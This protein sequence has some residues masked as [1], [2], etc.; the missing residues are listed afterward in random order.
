MREK[1][2]RGGKPKSKMNEERKKA[3]EKGGGTPHGGAWTYLKLVAF[4]T[5]QH[6]KQISQPVP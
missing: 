5:E 6:V 1:E 4:C 3:D 2:Q